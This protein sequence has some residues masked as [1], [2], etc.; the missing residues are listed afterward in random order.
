VF[1]TL[2]RMRYNFNLP[3]AL[4]GSWQRMFPRPPGWP[5]R[6]VL[7]SGAVMRIGDVFSG[8]TAWSETARDALRIM[9]AHSGLFVPVRHHGFQPRM[10]PRGWWSYVNGLKAVFAARTKHSPVEQHVGQCHRRPL[11]PAAP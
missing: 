1:D 10:T 11:I 3:P 9:D 2:L 6:V 5:L 8:E 7:T 4:L